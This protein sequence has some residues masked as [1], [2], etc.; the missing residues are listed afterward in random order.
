MKRFLTL[1]CLL[2]MYVPI[3][4][5][6][7]QRDAVYYKNLVAKNAA[8]TGLSVSDIENSRI[9]DAYYDK[10]ANASIV[11]LQ[12]TFKGVDVNKAIRVITFR[13]EKA[14]T[15]TGESILISEDKVNMISGIP[16]VSAIKAIQSVT[17]DLGINITPYSLIA[18]K[19]EN[20]GRIQEFGKLAGAAQNNVIAKLLWE[21][22]ESTGKWQLCWQVEFLTNKDNAL[23]HYYIDAQNNSI[24]QKKNLTVYEMAPG[25]VL[26]RPRMVYISEENSV[27]T[28]NAENNA[29]SINSSKYNVIPYPSEN[30]LEG[31][32]TLVNNPWEQNGDQDANTLKWNN[33]GTTDY[34]TTRGNNVY[35]QANNDGKDATFGYSPSSSTN[36]P[37]LNFN[38]TP[39]F[40]QDPVEDFFTQ[41]FNITNLFYWNNLMHDMSYQYGFDE[42]GGNFQ[43]SNISRGG[44]ET[45]EV[46]ADAQDASGTD[47]A[48]FATPVDGS[49][50]RMQMFLWSPGVLKLMYAN[51]PADYAGYK[52]S[53]ESNVSNSNKIAQ[54]GT[55]T[56]DVVI[57]KDAAHPDSSTAC[58]AA[59]NASELLGKI[60]YID[61]GSCS[62]TVKFHNAQSAGAKAIIVGNVAPDDPRYPTGGGNVLVTMSA[63]PLDNTITIPGVFVMYDTAVDMKNIISSGKTLNV[64]L[65][66]SPKIDGGLDNGVV[67]HEYTHGISTRLSGGP[68]NSSCISNPEAMGEGWSDYYSV[69]MTTD[70]SKALVTDGPKP[71]PLGN[72]AVGFDNSFSGIRTYPYSTDFAVN[73]WVYDTLRLSSDIKEYSLLDEL[74]GNIAYRYFVGDFWCTTLWEVTWELIKSYGISPSIFDAS[75]TGGNVVA[76]K[77]VTQGLKLQKCSPGCVDGRDAILK[78]DTVL[79]GGKYS[80]ELW[81][82]FARR[83][84]GYSANEGSVSKI[85]DGIGAYD[86]PT[87]LPVKWGSFTAAKQGNAALLKWT[88]VSENNADKFIVERSTDGRTYTAIGEVKAANSSN[89]S[90]YSLTDNKPFNGNNNYRIKQVDKDGKSDYSDIRSLNFADLR[91]LITLAPNPAKDFVNVKVEGNTDVLTLQL[92][93]NTG[94]VIGTYTM[95]GENYTINISSLAHGIY[96]LSISGKGYTAKYRLVVQ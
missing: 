85:K 79:F 15:V 12:Q 57:F 4:V 33:D 36:P 95:S 59:A 61:R 73:P 3:V 9:A 1:A 70:W 74:Q 20:N 53:R 84:L 77:L 10:I 28:P 39:D 80:K 86:L 60:A 63:T 17:N 7:Q 34:K 82:A 93:S 6:A 83:G 29:Q 38:F 88:T 26:N 58:G 45:D 67:A 66:P 50:P 49:K 46:I 41:S 52:L 81:K 16:S 30:P 43:A 87:A 54:S 51:A 23:W 13:N 5:K 71:K 64:S 90:S 68:S 89:G 40:D 8:A 47:N 72:Y 92:T 55:I 11:Y 69:M 37:D 25:A 35:A 65:K 31:A 19:S 44:K 76:L 62:F 96:N 91:P 56:S 27:N 18:S 14:V 2:T 21:Q 32:P 78:A 75:G 24:F 48:N 42:V 22:N 94:Q